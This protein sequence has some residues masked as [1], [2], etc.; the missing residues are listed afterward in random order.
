MTQ[1]AG[2]KKSTAKGSPSKPTRVQ[3]GRFTI[4]MR[5]KAT[6]SIRNI[7]S[8]FGRWL[9]S[10]PGSIAAQFAG[11]ATGFEGIED[12]DIAEIKKQSRSKDKREAQF[13]KDASKPKLEE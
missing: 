4:D 3:K 1:P 8:V 5:P 6:P 11:I 7:V 9:Q 10:Y 12:E 2:E 13:H